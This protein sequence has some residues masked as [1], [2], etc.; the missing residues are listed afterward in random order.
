M[1]VVI[2]CAG[3]KTG[4]A[5]FTT[6]DGRCVVFVACPGAP[7]SDPGVL[8]AHPDDPSDRPG[9]TWRERV[10]AENQRPTLLPPLLPAGQLYAPK[11][12]AGLER[13]LGPERLFILSAGWGL[14]RADFLLP[15]YDITFS[16]AADPHKQR[17]K[18][19]RFDDFNALSAEP[20]DDTVFLGGKDYVPLFATLTKSVPGRRL[21]FVRSKSPPD[22]PGCATQRY[23]TRTRTNWHYE[24]ATALVS[25]EVVPRFDPA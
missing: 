10:V 3:R 21:V 19:H 4:K 18:A 6:S 16:K 1:R 17:G 2:Q 15:T 13:H 12:Y 24:C 7:R 23:C 22:V 11:A 14:V 5:T 20:E 8:F 9:Q 25:G